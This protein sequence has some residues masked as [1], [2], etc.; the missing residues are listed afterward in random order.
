MQRF[1]GVAD[2]GIWQSV[3]SARH[4][5]LTM[6]CEHHVQ[7]HVQT[8]EGSPLISIPARLLEYSEGRRNPREA[9]RWPRRGI[10]TGTRSLSASLVSCH[11]FATLGFR[12][13]CFTPLRA[14]CGS[15]SVRVR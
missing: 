3:R 5:A 1:H 11:G 14:S 12:H 13:G 2:G 6:L 15:Q 10:R 4:R 7:L 9:L 8:R